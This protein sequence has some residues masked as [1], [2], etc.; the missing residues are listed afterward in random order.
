ME[1]TGT[2]TEDHSVFNNLY[3]HDTAALPHIPHI[4]VVYIRYECSDCVEN[5]H[6]LS[7]ACFTGDLWAVNLYS[8]FKRS[9]LLDSDPQFQFLFSW[10]ITPWLELYE[11]FVADQPIL[12]R[13]R[14][15]LCILFHGFC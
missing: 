2:R 8:S 14:E 7:V 6:F 11:R 1:S 9:S 5:C 12:D 3:S 10:D 4:H 13:E 15:S